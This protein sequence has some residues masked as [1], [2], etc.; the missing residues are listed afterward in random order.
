MCM[1]VYVC[2][3][4]CMYVCMYVFVLCMCVYVYL[5]CSKKDDL[6]LPLSPA[7]ER[8]DVY[9]TVLAAA[10]AVRAAGMA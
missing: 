8:L 7:V 5:S 1:Y 3:Y 2:M 9:L 6:S 4:G 10:P